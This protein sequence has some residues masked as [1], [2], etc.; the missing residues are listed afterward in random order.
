[1]TTFLNAKIEKETEKAVMISMWAE[2][3]LTFWIPKSQIISIGENNIVAA[4]WLV[5]NLYEAFMKSQ[6]V[7]AIVA[8]STCKSYFI[9]A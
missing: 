2:T 9:K 5:K 4:D 7:A 3:A 1:M 6:R 8:V